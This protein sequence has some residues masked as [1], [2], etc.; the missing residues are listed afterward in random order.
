MYESGK[1]TLAAV[2]RIPT[3]WFTIVDLGWPLGARQTLK[4]LSL[5]LYRR[6]PSCFK[7]D[8]KTMT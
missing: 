3:K 6:P 4:S 2:T 5:L 8:H 7:D 1:A